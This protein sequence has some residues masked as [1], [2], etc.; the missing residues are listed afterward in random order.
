MAEN[1]IIPQKYKPFE[2]LVL[3]GNTIINGKFPIVIDRNPVFLIGVGDPPKLWLNIRTKNNEWFY[4][5][6]DGVSKDENIRVLHSGR[7]ISIYFNDKIIVQGSKE[8]ESHMIITHIDLT[9]F[10]FA[11]QG[12]LS[13]LKIGGHQMTGNTFENVE[14]IVNIK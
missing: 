6:E 9:P 12:D 13:S 10:G 8:D 4:V 1:I 5:V 14:I 2:K 7:I 3:C 11:I